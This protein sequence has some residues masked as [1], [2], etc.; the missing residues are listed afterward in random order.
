MY[1]LLYVN[2]YGELPMAHVRSERDAVDYLARRVEVIQR[3][4]VR[5]GERIV[6][7]S[8]R[9]GRERDITDMVWELVQKY[10][11]LCTPRRK[12]RARR[13]R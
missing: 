13:R 12:V 2:R 10:L 11:P 4:G 5:R 1:E 9:T 8:I 3:G 7:R 6:L